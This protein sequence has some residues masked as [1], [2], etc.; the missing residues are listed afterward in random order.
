MNSATSVSP[1]YRFCARCPAANVRY[2]PHEPM[3]VSSCPN[4]SLVALGLAHDD[5]RRA[6]DHA[7]PEDHPRRDDP[8]LECEVHAIADGKNGDQRARPRQQPPAELVFGV[9]RG[10]GCG[11][12]ARL[13]IKPR[14]PGNHGRR[15]GVQGLRRGRR[16][17][18]ARQHPEAALDAQQPRLKRLQSSSQ[19]VGVVHALRARTRHEEHRLRTMRGWESEFS[20]TMEA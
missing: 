14:R 15:P 5:E 19:L 6:Q 2:R 12:R 13:E 4:S 1:S 8:V 9:L 10:D 20:A 17:D 16:G 7:T 18:R 11:L 3:P